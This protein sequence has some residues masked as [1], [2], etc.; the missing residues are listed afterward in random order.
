MRDA[1]RASTPAQRLTPGRCRSTA[2]PSSWASCQSEAARHRTP[3]MAKIPLA[4]A[5]SLDEKC[6]SDQ[7]GA[8]TPSVLTK[9]E[10]NILC[11]TTNA[12]RSVQPNSADSACK[13]KHHGGFRK[14][15]WRVTGARGGGCRNVSR[16]HTKNKVDVAARLAGGPSGA[17]EKKCSASGPRQCHDAA[18]ASAVAVP[19]RF[20]GERA[21]RQCAPQPYRQVRRRAGP[22]GVIWPAIGQARRTLAPIHPIHGHWISLPAV[23]R[24]AHGTS[25]SYSY[26]ASCKPVALR[27]G[28]LFWGRDEML[29]RPGPA[30]PD[31][32]PIGAPFAMM[33]AH[34]TPSR[35][36]QETK[37]PCAV[38]PISAAHGCSSTAPT[39]RR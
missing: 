24:A 2:P 12:V 17:M 4:T 3:A 29:R 21:A 16:W 14:T 15:G 20:C 10:Y 34:T 19:N 11:R 5:L 28:G 37:E 22:G 32:L 8:S 36:L 18:S 1:L 30:S 13:Y 35:R 25:A 39:R 7:A 33:T 31:A 38:P 9:T 26:R 6:R 23:M 27:R